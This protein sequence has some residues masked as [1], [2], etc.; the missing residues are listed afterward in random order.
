ML[1]IHASGRD[2]R[3]SV[4]DAEST[5]DGTPGH[6]LRVQAVFVVGLGTRGPHDAELR[7]DLS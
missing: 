1:A 3:K 2:Q 7:V 6:R 4:T 5:C